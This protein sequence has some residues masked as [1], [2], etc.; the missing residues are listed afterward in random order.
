MAAV[1]N[2]VINDGQAT[3][4]AHTFVPI[5]FR[6]G[7]WLFEDQSGTS[8][9]GFNKI[10]YS[11]TRPDPT[12]SGNSKNRDS[13]CVIKVWVPVLE[14]LGVS[15]AGITPPPT[16]SYVLGSAHEFRI[17]ERSSPQNRKDLRAYS[18][19]VLD[20]AL[21]IDMLENLRASY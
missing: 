10:T 2:M 11:L 17:P 1:A 16:I 3:P 12:T 20:N 6:N 18:R 5:S 7:V 14:T 4:V 13:R 15:D 8:P 9:I 19:N 21:V